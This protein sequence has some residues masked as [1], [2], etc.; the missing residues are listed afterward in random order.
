M[1]AV[2]AVMRHPRHY[3]REPLRNYRRCFRIIRALNSTSLLAL[4][5]LSILKVQCTGVGLIRKMPVVTE[6]MLPA[7]SVETV[8]FSSPRALLL[9]INV[10]SL[11]GQTGPPGRIPI[12]IN[13]LLG[14]GVFGTIFVTQLLQMM[15]INRI[16]QSR[17]LTGRK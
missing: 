12:T 11:A 14:R 3:S 17:C 1:A 4:M 6:S 5:L 2:H 10:H 15:S 16:G 8:P 13:G 9:S 7:T